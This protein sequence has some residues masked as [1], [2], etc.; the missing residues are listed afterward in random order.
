MRDIK[1]A[2][3][4]FDT[5]ALL[6]ESKYMDVEKYHDSLDLYCELL[7][8]KNASILELA[9]GPGNITQYLLSKNTDLQIVATDLSTKMLDLAQKNNPNASVSLLDCRAMNEVKEMYDGIVCGF[10]L[11]YV[12][13]EEAIQMIQDAGKILNEGGLFYIST[14]EDDYSASGYRGNS[15]NPNQ[16]LMMYF[17]ESAYLIEALEQS[18]FEMV[19][20]SRVTYTDDKGEEVIDL[21]LIGKKLKISK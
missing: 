7:P 10:G 2:A 6:Y 3:D 4:I 18:G 13:K 9:C 20:E 11:P 8:Q 16:G 12:S 21:I 14:M 1:N 15:V 19:Y 17:H 5:Y